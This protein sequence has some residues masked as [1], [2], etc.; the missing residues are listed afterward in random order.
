MYHAH[1]LQLQGKQ[2]GVSKEHAFGAE[3]PWVTDVQF[4]ECLASVNVEVPS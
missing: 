1:P 2:T 4:R 3:P